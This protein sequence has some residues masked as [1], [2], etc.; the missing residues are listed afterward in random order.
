M[1]IKIYETDQITGSVFFLDKEDKLL[2]KVVHSYDASY[3]TLFTL[4]Y[5]ERGVK[6]CDAMD[7]KTYYDEIKQAIERGALRILA[8]GSTIEI[9]L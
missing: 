4:Y 1:K 8:T 9:K 2:M 5:V 3:G 7:A 6:Y